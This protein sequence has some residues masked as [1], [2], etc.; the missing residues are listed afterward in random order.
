MISCFSLDPNRDLLA[1]AK[2]TESPALAGSPKLELSRARQS[3]RILL[4]LFWTKGTTSQRPL[5]TV[6]TA[7]PRHNR[8]FVD[9]ST[10]IPD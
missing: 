6:L 7:K 4:V 1:L 2:P 5:Q 9:G 3:G 8:G 10:R